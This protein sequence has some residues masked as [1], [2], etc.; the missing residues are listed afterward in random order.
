MSFNLISK[1]FYKFLL[2][3]LF[4]LFRGFGFGEKLLGGGKCSENFI[5]S[6]K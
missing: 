1:N 6:I 4:I 2:V 5:N 3:S